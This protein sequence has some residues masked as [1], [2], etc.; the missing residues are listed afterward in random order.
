MQTPFAITIGEKI[1]Q[2]FINAK[3][4]LMKL[5][6]IHFSKSILKLCLF[7]NFW[8][9][10]NGTLETITT[11]QHVLLLFETTYLC[12]KTFSTVVAIKSMYH[13]RF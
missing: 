11:N 8:F 10:Y 7:L 1:S 6:W 2:L 3:E 5:F 9:I 4:F 12:E 13:N